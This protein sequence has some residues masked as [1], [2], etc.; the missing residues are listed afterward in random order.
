[1][2]KMKKLAA[3]LL[4][5]AMA[6]SL[7]VPAAFAVSG[8]SGKDKVEVIVIVGSD[9]PEDIEKL[10]FDDGTCVG[11]YDYS[12]RY[13]ETVSTRSPADLVEYFVY[14]YWMYRGDELCLAMNPRTNVRTDYDTKEKAWK[15]LEDPSNGVASSDYWPKDAQKLKTFR[16]Q[17]DCHYVGAMN[18][19]EW[20]LEPHRTA[21]SFAAVLAAKCNP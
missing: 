16:W 21:G 11:D 20:N 5:V 8:N 3:V 1:M 14:A 17:Y 10:R 13:A 7:V 2:T 19:E 12:I 15:M 9:A 18:E 4:A 6:A